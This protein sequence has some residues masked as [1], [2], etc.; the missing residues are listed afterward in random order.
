MRRL[1]TICERCAML[2]GCEV[3]T[4]ATTERCDFCGRSCERVN[5]KVWIWVERE[6]E[7]TNA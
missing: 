6:D 5:G 7:H 4:I 3:L 1:A 2:L